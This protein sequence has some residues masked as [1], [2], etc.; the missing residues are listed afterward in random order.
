MLSW[1]V[2]LGCGNGV[3]FVVVASG[4]VLHVQ[5]SEE[6]VLSLSSNEFA[7]KWTEYR[8]AV[9]RVIGEVELMFYR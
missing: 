1:S 4:L 7:M 2:I 5:G 6:P 8:G 9:W 3:I